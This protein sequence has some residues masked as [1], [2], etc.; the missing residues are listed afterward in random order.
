MPGCRE[1]SMP[2]KKRVRSGASCLQS[3]LQLKAPQ[4]STSRLFSKC[5]G[6]GRRHQ[7]DRPCRGGNQKRLQNRSPSP[8]S[9]LL[10]RLE[11]RCDRPPRHLGHVAWRFQNPPKCF[12]KNGGDDETRTRDL[13]RD[14][15]LSCTVR[16]DAERA[17]V[18]CEDRRRLHAKLRAYFSLTVSEGL[19]RMV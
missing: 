4:S 6:H 11:I 16:N 10:S 14:S 13:C 2:R 1:G 3:C 8:D 7:P 18:D 12:R 9:L 17:V 15:S 5:C 19:G